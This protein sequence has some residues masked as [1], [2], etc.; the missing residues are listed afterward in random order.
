MYPSTAPVIPRIQRWIDNVLVEV[1]ESTGVTRDWKNSPETQ[2]E[3][4][5]RHN[6][7]KVYMPTRGLYSLLPD[8]RANLSSCAHYKFPVSLR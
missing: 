8:L 7:N 5:I 6:H 2:K 4:Q 1:V 3:P